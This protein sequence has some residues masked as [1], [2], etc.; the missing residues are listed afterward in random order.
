MPPESIL[1]PPEVT[2]C[3][4]SLAISRPEIDHKSTIVH[5]H[6]VHA[7]KR[8]E[9]P[10]NFISNNPARDRVRKIQVGHAEFHPVQPAVRL[11][12]GLAAEH[13]WIAGQPDSWQYLYLYIYIDINVCI[14][15]WICKYLYSYISIYVYTHMYMFRHISINLSIETYRNVE[16]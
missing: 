5:P 9:I 11:D 6:I 12:A 7:S 10:F 1:M 13:S 16:K 8:F 3:A 4:I 2:I 14:S 15:I